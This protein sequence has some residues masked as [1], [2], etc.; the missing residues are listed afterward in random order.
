MQGKW[1]R[2]VLRDEIRR[3]IEEMGVDEFKSRLFDGFR[4]GEAEKDGLIT[5]L[6][7]GH[8]VL[9]LGPPGSGKTT[10]AN[11][12][13]NILNDIEVVEGCPLNC[14]PADASCSWCL[15]KKSQGIALSPSLLRGAERIKRV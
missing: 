9:I 11:R 1:I 6:L 7:S 4:I 2:Y 13:A 8:H 10:L 3:S 14:S 15:D 5:S 12:I